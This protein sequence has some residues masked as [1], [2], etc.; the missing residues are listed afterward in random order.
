MIFHTNLNIKQQK[1][2][3]INNNMILL[4]V[5]IIM[6]G[7]NK[8]CDVYYRIIEENKYQK[9]NS[10]NIMRLIERHEEIC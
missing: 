10:K 2:L 3:D 4:S 7:L 8:F 6:I 5:F 9:N 1:H